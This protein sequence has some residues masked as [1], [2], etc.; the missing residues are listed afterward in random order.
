[1]TV[2]LPSK[3]FFEA[4]DNSRAEDHNYEDLLLRYL[5]AKRDYPDLNRDVSEPPVPLFCDTLR[6]RVIREFNRSL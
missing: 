4:A 6:Q 5:A 1:M 2:G 3:Y